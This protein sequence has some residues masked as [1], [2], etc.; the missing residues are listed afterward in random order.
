MEYINVIKAVIYYNCFY[1]FVFNK[2]S[3][4]YKIM[5]ILCENYKFCYIFDF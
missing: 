5:C 3:S 1:M 4:R 2:L